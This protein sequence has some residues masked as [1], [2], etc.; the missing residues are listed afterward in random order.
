MDLK[1]TEA[2]SSFLDFCRAAAATMVLLAH[3]Q[4]IFIPGSP[5]Q[6]PGSFGVVIFFLLSGYL[7]TLSLY[8]RYTRPFPQLGM[9]VTDRISRIY[10]PYLPA[11]FLVVVV[12]SLFISGHWASPGVSTGAYSFVSNVFM[13]SDYPFFQATYHFRDISQLYPRPYNTA[14]QFWTVAVE[15]WIYIFV[16]LVA[17]WFLRRE[18]VRSD[19]CV[20][21]L[22]LSTPVVVWNSFAGGGGCLALVWALGGLFSFINILIRRNDSTRIAVYGLIFFGYGASCLTARALA[23]SFNPYDLSSAFF[24]GCI[25]FGI[26]FLAEVWTIKSA[27]S[28]IAAILSS[29]SYSLYLTHNTLVILIKEHSPFDYQANLL[30]AFLSCHLFAYCF[31]LLFERHYRLVG[32]TIG[33]FISRC[34]DAAPVRENQPARFAPRQ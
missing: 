14:G 3:M 25:M 19:I 2:S 5:I 1:L 32:R 29:Y 34:L 30:I 24:I 31:Y 4:H 26:C 7:I 22:L 15:V 16:G 10:T 12:N 17:F 13:L 23:I 20:F 18:T 11:L 9:F 33:P 28:R 21:A 6:V 27:V 8:N